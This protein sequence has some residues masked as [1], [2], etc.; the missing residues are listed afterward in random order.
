M[1]SE[2]LKKMIRQKTY[3]STA[4]QWAPQEGKLQMLGRFWEEL[5]ESSPGPHSVRPW[6]LEHISAPRLD[7]V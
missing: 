3:E 1:K 5:S 7:A 4:E 2:S 6:S